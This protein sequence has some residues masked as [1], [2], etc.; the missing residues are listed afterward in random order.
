M[1]VLPWQLV[2]RGLKPVET[3]EGLDPWVVAS[4]DQAG[5]EVRL[6]LHEQYGVDLGQPENVYLALAIL[7]LLHDRVLTALRDHLMCAHGSQDALSLIKSL[8]FSI[9]PSAPADAWRGHAEGDR[10]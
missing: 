10:P 2:Q 6:I 4:V 3:I 5:A 8:E 7:D 9:A 1:T